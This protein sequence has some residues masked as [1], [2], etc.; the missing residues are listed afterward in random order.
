[1]KADAAAAYCQPARSIPPMNPARVCLTRLRRDRFIAGCLRPLA[2]FAVFLAVFYLALS[3]S[4]SGITPM[5]PLDVIFGNASKANEVIFYN[6]RLPRTAT[7]AVVGAALSLAGVVMQNVLRNPLASA[8]TLGV[9]QGAA[10]GAAL[11]IVF[12]HA[13]FGAD[14]NLGSAITVTSP[15]VVAGCAFVFGLASGAVVLALSLLTRITPGTMILSG[16]AMGAMFAG[17]T[18]IIQYFADDI[19]VASIVYWTFGDVGR[20]GWNQI[21][22]L[23]A[24]FALA[25]VYF[26]RNAWNYNAISN[27]TSTAVSLGVNVSAVLILGMFVASLLSSI[28][29]AFVGTISFIGLIA[30]HLARHF[31]GS[32]HRQLLLT[33]ALTGAMLLIG[34]EVLSR[35]VVSPTVLPIGAITSFLGAPVFLYMIFRNDGWRKW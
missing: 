31:V 19:K 11:A 6:I 21:G 20:T 15:F 5:L 12:F 14:G 16:I 34:A 9:S 27:G 24:V 18:A 23:A 33:S 3:I 32:D 8:S 30:P 26:Q 10:F 35:T 25:F 29:V 4:S 2:F 7:A 17:G 22:I 28:A 13:G 1:M